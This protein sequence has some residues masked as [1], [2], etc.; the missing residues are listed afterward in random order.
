MSIVIYRVNIFVNLKLD[1][2]KSTSL[3]Y[4]GNVDKSTSFGRDYMIGR[5]EAF[6][7]ALEGLSSSWSKI[8]TEELKPFGL[9]GSYVLYLI[10]LYKN[11]D[12]LTSTNLCEICNKDKADVSRGI[13]ALESKGLVVREN[14]S[15]NRYRAKITL[16]EQGKTTTKALRERVKLAVEK[17]GNGLTEEQREVFY[18]ALE[19]IAA[20][21]KEMSKE[22]LVK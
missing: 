7:F 21:L 13:K 18:N 4:N 16:T 2:D 10:A 8:A 20:N 22:G 3:V 12:G 11:E 15:V 19:I 9:K 1:V 14:A 17:G 5:F 6:S